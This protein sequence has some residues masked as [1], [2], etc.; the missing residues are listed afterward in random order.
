MGKNSVHFL[1]MSLF[2]TIT[3]SLHT[4]Q[5]RVVFSLTDIVDSQAGVTQDMFFSSI[6]LNKKLNNPCIYFTKWSTLC[7]DF[8]KIYCSLT[9]FLFP[10]NFNP[11]S[12]PNHQT[13]SAD[14]GTIKLGGYDVSM[15]EGNP[16]I[17]SRHKKK[18]FFIFK[19]YKMH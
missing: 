1:L 6:K 15:K 3:H 17:R 7:L 19:K 5:L 18:I 4:V 12:W 13:T 16:C 8:Q 14:P 2:L 9:L 11:D 10:F